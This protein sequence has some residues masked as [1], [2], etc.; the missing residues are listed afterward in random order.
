[1]LTDDEYDPIKTFKT[2][3]EK[4]LYN[5]MWV[6]ETED[7]IPLHSMNDTHLIKAYL[8]CCKGEAA[9][10]GMANKWKPVLFEEIERRKLTL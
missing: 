4:M 6:M 1:M 7:V 9:A 2:W 10:F 8:L 5:R 3:L